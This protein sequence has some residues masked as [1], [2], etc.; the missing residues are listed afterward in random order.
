MAG[1]QQPQTGQVGREA[2]AFLPD[3]SILIGGAL[4]GVPFE[5]SEA[6]EGCAMRASVLAEDIVIGELGDVVTAALD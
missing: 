6:E 4:N 1:C 5:R 2:L 3:L